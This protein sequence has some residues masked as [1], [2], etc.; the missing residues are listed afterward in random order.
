VSSATQDPRDTRSTVREESLI[1]N[2]KR[3]A[4]ET[5]TLLRQEFELARAEIT[6]KLRGLG[7]GAA[8]LIIAALLTIAALATLTACLILALTLV[9]APWLAALIVT[10]I[11]LL[12]ALLFALIGRS[13]ITRALPPIP[14]QTIQT[15][16][17]DIEWLKIRTKS[18][19]P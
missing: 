8:L 16:K 1:E 5:S 19:R 2:L 4:R 12:G 11:Y 6:Q 18:R 13:R 9:V 3:L 15:L 14:E 17:E 10:A 7:L